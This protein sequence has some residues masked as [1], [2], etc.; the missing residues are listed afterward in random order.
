MTRSDSGRNGLILLIVLWVM[1]VL[2]ILGT[3]YYHL[4]TIEFLT[5]RNDLEKLQAELLAESALSYL[6]DNF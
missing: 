4:S 5:N 2:S 3:S 6:R 1:V